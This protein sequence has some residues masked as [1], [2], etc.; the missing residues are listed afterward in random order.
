LEGT[1]SFTGDGD[2]MRSHLHNVYL[3]EWNGKPEIFVVSLGN[4]WSSPRIAGKGL[5]WFD[6]DSGKFVTTTTEARLNARSAAQQADGTFFVLTQEPSGESTKLAVLTKQGDSLQL[7]ALEVLPDRD[8]GDGGAD[9]V[10]GKEENTVWCT[11]RTAGKG[12]LYNYRY[13]A[14]AGKLEMVRSQETGRKPRHMTVLDN[15][16][17]VSCDKDDN[18]LTVFKGLASSPTQ[19]VQTVKVPTVDTVSFFYQ[20]PGLADVPDVTTTP[21]ANCA[22]LWEQCGG[23][24]FSGATCCSQG[25]TC[26]FGNQWYSQCSPQ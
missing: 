22:G 17:I 13:Q 24:S 25:L 1:F 6:R 3:F 12:K 21:A 7:S 11:D 15:G 10:L 14:A 8:G 23:Q 4:P 26:E 16:D 5:V 9:V 19:A 18:T 2:D 20:G